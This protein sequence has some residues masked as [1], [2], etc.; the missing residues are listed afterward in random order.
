MVKGGDPR[1]PTGGLPLGEE[2]VDDTTS[3][4]TTNTAFIPNADS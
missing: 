3:T 2:P 4:K 1:P